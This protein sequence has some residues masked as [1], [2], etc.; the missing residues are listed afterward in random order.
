MITPF[1]QAVS[2]PAPAAASVREGPARRANRCRPFILAAT[3]CSAMLGAR[4]APA[5][6]NGPLS[7]ITGR[8]SGLVVCLGWN[9][10]ADLENLG[11]TP[12]VL[13][14]GLALDRKTVE[15]APAGCSRTMPT[16]PL[17]WIGGTEPG[18]PIPTIS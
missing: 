2:R 5:L 17:P 8:R 18:C 6:S 1:R 11:R 9:A 13:V 16:V 12:N 14:H 3:L 15:A 10:P 4:A 7:E